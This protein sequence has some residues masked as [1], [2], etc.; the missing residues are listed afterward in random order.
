MTVPV[1]YAYQRDVVSRLMF[2]VDDRSTALSAALT[3]CTQGNRANSDLPQDQA[4]P[5]TIDDLLA[6]W[7]LWQ[8]T[9]MHMAECLRDDPSRV[10][11]WADVDS[12]VWD[13]PL[14]RDPL[15]LFAAANYS[16]HTQ[17][18]EK[19]DLVGQKVGSG[20]GDPYL[21]QKPLR[22][23]VGPTDPVIKPFDVGQMDWEVELALVIGKSGRRIPRDNA[24]S[25]VAGYMVCNDLSARDFVRRPDWPMFSS[26]WFAQKS[27]DTFTP[28]GPVLVPSAAI[29][30]IDSLR[31]RLWIGDELMQDGNAGQMLFSIPDQIEFASR[32]V[33]LKPGDV[34]STGTPAG[35]GMATGRYLQAG[36][37]MTAEITN[38]GRQVTTVLDEVERVPTSA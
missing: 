37:T 1:G 16:A 12:V 21:F 7:E 11:G 35:V 32:F 28:I 2:V 29:P 10:S 3:A 4:I 6:D 20:D 25:H 30:D 36:E 22:S 8:D 38:L 23:V 26:D 15:M 18:A 34:I 31:L 13:P 27:F 17:E 33:T 14:V 9:A 24:M 5:L 19:S